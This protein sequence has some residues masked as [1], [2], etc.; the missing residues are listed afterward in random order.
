MGIKWSWS[1]GTEDNDDLQE[2]GWDPY[3]NGN[4]Y[5]STQ[6]SSPIYSYP[7]SPG[8]R[9]SFTLRRE[10]N[11]IAPA[12]ILAAE[13]WVSVS[14]YCPDLF[15]EYSDRYHAIKIT[16]GNSGKSIKV[17]SNVG[18]AQTMVLEV[19]NTFDPSGSVTVT[20][21]DWHIISLQY[22]MTGT[23]WAARWYL[24]G[25]AV[26]SLTSDV[27]GTPADA[28][29]LLV[30]I[31]GCSATNDLLTHYGHIV[32]YDDWSDNGQQQ[33]Y[34]TRVS[35][36]TNLGGFTSGSW[37]P[38]GAASNP[39]AVESPFNTSSYSLNSSTSTGEKLA[40]SAG[41][42]TL[43]SKLGIG[44]SST[45]YGITNHGFVT[46]SGLSGSIGI[47]NTSSPGVYHTGDSIFPDTN[48]PTYGYVSSGS[49]STSDSPVMIYE[50]E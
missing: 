39:E 36:D 33:V 25:V 13:G 5:Y 30:S 48:D 18:S 28:D 27:T 29:N 34:V 1:F 12:K 4:S 37:S 26:G 11:L 44:V 43:A 16:D 20:Q 15:N 35:P 8:G 6:S 23:T 21:G 10:A 32:C 7:G 45:I 41:G 14:F 24:D 46:G 50:V 17:Y 40:V 2:M 9:K 42:A 22:S 3:D 19:D 38:V 31:A 49:F 47:G